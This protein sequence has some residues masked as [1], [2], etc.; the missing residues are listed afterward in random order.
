MEAAAINPIIAAKNP[1]AWTR[2]TTS[3]RA[4]QTIQLRGLKRQPPPHKEST[5]NRNID[6]IAQNTNRQSSE[7]G[8]G[9]FLSP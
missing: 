1:T 3:T 7:A 5:H 8:A 9:A 2:K 4:T 6:Q